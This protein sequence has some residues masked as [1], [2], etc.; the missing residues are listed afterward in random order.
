MNKQVSSPQMDMRL[1]HLDYSIIPLY[2]LLSIK[3]RS[4]SSRPIS[5]S[6]THQDRPS[7][8]DKTIRTCYCR[9]L[10]MAWE[11]RLVYY[12]TESK[13]LMTFGF[14]ILITTKHASLPC[15][16]L[17]DDVHESCPGLARV[18]GALRGQSRVCSGISKK[19]Y[20]I[21]A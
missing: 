16:M 1:A 11:Q 9:P 6:S 21:N 18:L 19:I 5:G 3:P 7:S 20:L 4:L 8:K 10:S 17:S 15:T 2:L 14:P 12:S 13:S